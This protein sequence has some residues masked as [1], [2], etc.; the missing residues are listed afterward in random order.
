MRNKHSLFP[1]LVQRRL[2][3][4]P[5]FVFLPDSDAAT[6]S[7]QIW[8]RAGTSAEEKG[9]DGLA[10]FL[11]HLVFKGSKN[12]GVG[13]LAARVEASGGDINA[14]T[15]SD[16]TYYYL[17]CL[18]EAA[19]ECMDILADAVWS[20]SL[21]ERLARSRMPSA[22]AKSLA[23]SLRDSAASRLEAVARSFSASHAKVFNPSVIKLPLLSY[24][25]VRLAPETSTL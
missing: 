12:L 13:E 3:E 21:C 16:A 4:G 19:E 15:M 9:E 25:K 2:P 18:P 8:F 5:A 14:Y 6:A 23:C 17:T 20:P 11:E 24:V 1:D 7:I 10:P 22:R